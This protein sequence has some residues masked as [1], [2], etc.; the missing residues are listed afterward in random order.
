M[1]VKH[2]KLGP[3]GAHRWLSCTA[4]PGLIEVAQADTGKAGIYALEGSVAHELAAYHGAKAAGANP[5][6]S[7]Y[8]AACADA[9]INNFDLDEMKGHADSYA[10]L[11][12]GLF[13]QYEDA[14]VVFEQRMTTGIS[15][16]WGTVDCAIYSP[17][18]LVV[19]DYKYGRGVQVQADDNPQ[20]KLYALGALHELDIRPKT[21]ELVVFQPRLSASAS[22]WVIDTADLMVWADR[23]R[24]IAGWIN[25]GGPVEFAPS[26]DSCRFCPAAGVCRARMDYIL[27]EDFGT[28]SDMV[29][30]EELGRALDRTRELENW[31]KQV[32]EAALTKIYNQSE[33]IPGWKVVQAHGRR[34]IPDVEA[35]AQRLMKSKF[36]KR[37][38]TKT[39]LIPL[40]QLDKLVGGA[41][42]L[43]EILGDLVVRTP[44]KPTLAPQE[45]K[46][47]GISALSQAQQEFKEN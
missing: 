18:H 28:P 38:T 35:A 12:G 41:E 14:Q 5:S 6:K 19:I 17:D 29:T 43:E 33:Q 16:V 13:R 4:S 36:R 40:G 7:V 39:Q 26:E 47:E 30:N 15:G 32:K 9:A 25:A 34:T 20:L 3:S 44:G 42:R 22:R 10:R 1:V 2:A 37:D 23:V 21:V 46:R 27:Q 8:D 11:V 45:D 24:E 31:V